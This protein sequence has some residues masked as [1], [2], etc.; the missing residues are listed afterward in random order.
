MT[1]LGRR[2]LFV[3]MGFAG[4]SALAHL[5]WNPIVAYWQFLATTLL[6]V[7]GLIFWLVREWRRLDLFVTKFYCLAVIFDIFAEGALQPFH[8][9][10]RDNLLCTGRMFLVFFAF[11][12]VL[13]P[14]ER[15]L[16]CARR[17][18]SC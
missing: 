7:A 13:R 18:G 11:W 16:S 10:T 5:V 4:M 14:V 6:F 12:L 1:R 3:A 9:C 2:E 8:K 17:R 15:W